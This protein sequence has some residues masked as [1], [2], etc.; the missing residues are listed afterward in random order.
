MG[1]Q[2]LWSR[3][4]TQ[5]RLVALLL[6]AVVVVVILTALV[7]QSEVEALRTAEGVNLESITALKANQLAQ[8]RKGRLD[9]ATLLAGRPFFNADFAAWL[10]DPTPE[11]ADELRESLAVANARGVY[12]NI[13]LF[14]GAGD[15]RLRLYPDRSLARCAPTD[16]LLAHQQRTL[17]RLHE[18]VRAELKVSEEEYHTL[19]NSS[20]VALNVSRLEDGCLMDVNQAFID[21]AGYSRSELIGRTS[22]EIGL[23]SA[24]TRA[25]TLSRMREAKIEATEVGI[26]RKSGEIRDCL[27]VADVLDLPGGRYLRISSMDITERKQAEQAQAFLSGIVTYSSDAI[28]GRDM[29]GRIVSWNASAERMFGYTAAEAIGQPAAVIVP[30]APPGRTRPGRRPGGAGCRHSTSSKQSGW[31]RTAA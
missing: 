12:A 6:V 19:F 14:D 5:W 24:A 13:A 20:P 30:P 10:A 4:R 27:I 7:Y 31:Q 25:G 16:Q 22:L 26:R 28:V 1:V 8:L 17:R 29:D 15:E 21:L 9:D 11:I 18:E 2:L 23:F 3:G